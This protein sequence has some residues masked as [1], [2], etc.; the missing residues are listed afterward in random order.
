MSFTGSGSHVHFLP[1]QNWALF[2]VDRARFL[3]SRFTRFQALLLDYGGTRGEPSSAVNRFVAVT[4]RRFLC[5]FYSGVQGRR[6]RD[7][8]FITT[9]KRVRDGRLHGIHMLICCFARRFRCST[10]MR[11]AG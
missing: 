8:A 2:H 5:R 11:N 6:R 1:R 4:A 3:A 7:R 10:G 9:V